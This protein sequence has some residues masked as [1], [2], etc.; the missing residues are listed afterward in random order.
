VARGLSHTHTHTH[1]H[2]HHF[3]TYTHTHTTHATLASFTHVVPTPLDYTFPVWFVT[4]YDLRLP[5]YVTFTRFT[6][7]VTFDLRWV[8]FTFTHHVTFT[9]CYVGLR[10]YVVALR[11]VTLRCYVALRCY[12]YHVY[13]CGLHM[14]H[15][16]YVTLPPHTRFAHHVRVTD[17][18][19]LHCGYRTRLH[20]WFGCTVVALRCGYVQCGYGYAVYTHAF[21]TLH[22]PVAV[23]RTLVAVPFAFGLLRCFVYGSPTGWVT[24][25]HGWITVPPTVLPAVLH[26]WITFTAYYRCTRGYRFLP[27]PAC[28][29]LGSA[30][31]VSSLPARFGFTLVHRSHVTT[32]D[33]IA[34]ARQR[35]PPLP[36]A[37]RRRLTRLAVFFFTAAVWLYRQVRVTR[38]AEH[39][40]NMARW[41]WHAAPYAP[42]A[43]GHLVTSPRTWLS[44]TPPSSRSDVL[45]EYRT[46]HHAAPLPCA[47]AVLWWILPTDMVRVLNALVIG[48]RAPTWRNI[49]A[50]AYCLA[51]RDSVKHVGI[52]DYMAYRRSPTCACIHRT[53]VLRSAYLQHHL[54]P[55]NVPS[56]AIAFLPACRWRAPPLL[57]AII[58]WMT[59][60]ALPAPLR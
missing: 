15:H 27:V 36:T 35:V 40:Q 46:Y 25:T 30:F 41:R 4:R 20:V 12:V 9:R 53:P 50:P 8:T 23:T 17:Y 47:A 42:C 52:V 51:F 22:T 31:A 43:A 5:F 24:V 14:P 26:T 39:F 11:L 10:C 16:G 59:D 60:D 28:P 7:T 34:P 3:H 56:P 6:F 58:R 57:G 1:T 44:A 21:T 54:L 29:V 49:L 48:H 2:T 38:A 55:A 45:P 13:V 18:V 32:L 19:G 37:R 33:F